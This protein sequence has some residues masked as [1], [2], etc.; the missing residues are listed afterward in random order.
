MNLLN[1]ILG[2]KKIIIDR[3]LGKIVSGRIGSVRLK[4]NYSWYASYLMPN[5]EE[6]SIIIFDGNHLEPNQ[7]QLIEVKTLLTNLKSFCEKVDRKLKEESRVLSPSERDALKNWRRVFFI[8]AIFP[9]FDELKLSLEICFEAFDKESKN[10]MIL[11]YE[12]EKIKS[13]EV[14]VE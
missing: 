3:T 8:G 10:Y 5:A 6:E 9:I 13:V 1:L 14:R 11:T 2:R 4:N 7:E 12:D